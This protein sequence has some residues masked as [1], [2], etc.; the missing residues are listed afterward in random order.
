MWHGPSD[1][2]LWEILMAMH[3]GLQGQVSLGQ[4][5]TSVTR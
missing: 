3:D 4:P 5:G 2:C 1:L